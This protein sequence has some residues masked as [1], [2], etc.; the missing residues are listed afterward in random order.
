MPPNNRNATQRNSGL[1]LE[2]RV[3]TACAY[4][5]AHGL[6]DIRRT[7]QQRRG[8]HMTVA[9]PGVSWVDFH[10]T[11][12]DGREIDFDVKSITGKTNLFPGQLYARQLAY[13][14]RQQ[15]RGH[16][17][18]VLLYD[19]Q[20][21]MAWV[22]FDLVEA[23]LGGPLFVREVRDGMVYTNNAPVEVDTPDV[24]L[25]F[26]G[27]ALRSAARRAEVAVADADC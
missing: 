4:Y 5:R 17:A 12:P 14:R 11:L 6:A 22:A 10:G 3:E 25:D 15:V 1:E 26:L 16:V 18:F 8:T 21:D 23:A 20:L 24:P 2:A 9:L 27:P 19:R 7:R 13:L